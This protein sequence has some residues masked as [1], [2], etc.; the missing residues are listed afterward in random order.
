MATYHVTSP[1][2]HTYEV[3]APEGA[4]EQDA[5]EYVQKN[6]QQPQPDEGMSLGS[7]AEQ[8]VGNIPSS[9]VRFG[10]D[11]IQPVIHPVSTLSNM[12]GV[13]AGGLGKMGVNI[14]GPAQMQ[15]ADQMA[16][17]AGQFFKNRYGGAENI[18][19]TIATDPVGAAADLATVLTGG[20]AI[21]GKIPMLGKAAAVASK[22]PFVKSALQTAGTAGTEI[23]GAHTGVG[24]ASLRAAKDAGAFSADRSA[25]YAGNKAHTLPMTDVLDMA[26]TAMENLISRRAAQYKEGMANLPIAETARLKAQGITNVSKKLKVLDMT[27][28]DKAVNEAAQINQFK[29]IN[30]APKSAE[31]MKDITDLVD[32]WKSLRP[33]EYHTAMGLDALK[34]S[35]GNIRQ[36][37]K[38]GTPERVMADKVYHATKNQIVM[39][40]PNYANVM[41]DYGEASDMIK[42][43]KQTFS[44]SDKASADTKLRKLQ[45]ILRNDVNANFGRRAE[46]GKLL[47]ENGAPDLMAALAGQA[48]SSPVPRG[49]SKTTVGAVSGIDALG[50]FAHGIAG[51]DPIS[52]A[53]LAGYMASSS[54]FITGGAYHKAGQLQRLMRENLGARAAAK[55]L[56]NAQTRKALELLNYQAGRNNSTV[57]EITLRRPAGWQPVR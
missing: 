10:K 40:D 52:A 24:G 55:A 8:A 51:V 50:T 39:Q 12:G 44:M 21:A 9:A 33:E 34:R 45:S 42:E 43:L 22:F 28:I 19:Q 46:L 3:N 11:M 15:Q 27:P 56:P 20:S 17:A 14:A 23:L 47:E 54:P 1:D 18:K 37:Q 25:I 35:L 31:T 49:L 38:P 41:K 6:M 5:I 48:H 36:A 57:P 32:K 7:M 13:I 26:D 16:N 29:G 30:L 53:G 4:S 2:G